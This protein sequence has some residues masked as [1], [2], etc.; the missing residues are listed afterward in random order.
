L[1]LKEREVIQNAL[2]LTRGKIYGDD[3]AAEML[4]IKPTTLASKIKKL[5]IVVQER[6]PRTAVVP[7]AARS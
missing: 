6:D 4:G 3:G 1:K 2:N 7:T 5:G